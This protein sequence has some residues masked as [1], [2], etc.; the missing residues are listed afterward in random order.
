MAA[1]PSAAQTPTLPRLIAINKDFTD[2]NEQISQ[3]A[4]IIGLSQD[5]DVPQKQNA[6]RSAHNV[7]GPRAEWALR[8]VLDKLKNQADPGAQARANSRSWMLLQWTIEILPISRCAN[9]LRDADFLSILEQTLQESFGRENAAENTSWEARNQDESDSSETV[10]GESPSRKRKRPSSGTANPSKKVNLGKNGLQQLFIAVRSVICAIT[11]KANIQSGLGQTVDSELMK[12]VLRGESYQADQAARVMKYWLMAAQ[13]LLALGTRTHSEELESVLDL[14]PVQELWDLRR[15]DAEDESGTSAEQFSAECL[16]PTLG[17]LESLRTISE[18]TYHGHSY[19]LEVGDRIRHLEKLIERHLLAPARAA[20]FSTQSP[21]SE[22]EPDTKYPEAGSFRVYLAPLSA[23]LLQ[24]AQLEDANEPVPVF[25]NSLYRAVPELLD[26]AIRFSPLRTPKKRLTEKPW[27]QAVFVALVDSIGCSLKAPEFG[28]PQASFTALEGCLNVLTQQDIAIDTE[29]L[30]DLFWFHSGVKYPLNQ[31]RNINWPLVAALV[32]LEPGMFL[33]DPKSR[34]S[35]SE[36]RPVELAGFLFNQISATNFTDSTAAD[37]EPMDIDGGDPDVGVA[38]SRYTFGRDETLSRVIIPIM[39][40]FARNRDLIGFLGKWDDQLCQTA[41]ISREPLKELEVPI[42]QDRALPIALAKLFEQSLTP[43]QISKLFQEHSDRIEALSVLGEVS[44]SDAL[45]L[46]KEAFSSTVIV[47][48]M[49]ECLESDE[50]VEAVKPQLLSLLKSFASHVHTDNHG[51][52][53]SLDAS[54]LVLCQ[55][56]NIIWPIGLHGSSAMQQEVLIPITE[57]AS[58]DVAT[59]RNHESERKIGSSTRAAAVLFLLCACGHLQTIPD[60]AELVRGYLRKALKSLSTSRFDLDDLRR[61]I[62]V[63]CTEFAPLIKFLKEDARQEAIFKLLLSI[64]EFEKEHAKQV[65]EALTQSISRDGGAAVQEP[66]IS[67]L[68]QAL[69]DGENEPLKAIVESSFLQ[70]NPL[71]VSREQREAAL[72]ELLKL[73]D[74]SPNDSALVLN[75]MVRFMHVPNA[76]AKIASSGGC[77]FDIAQKLHDEKLESP[78]ELQ[79]L[80]MLVQLTL[81][82]IIPNKDQDQNKRYLEKF[83]GKLASASKKAHK[84]FPARIAILRGTFLAQK[85]PSLLSP[86]A[87]VKVLSSCLKEGVPWEAVVVDALSE[88]ASKLSSSNDDLFSTAKAS[89]QSWIASKVDMKNVIATKHELS[90]TLPAELWPRVHAIVAKFQLYSSIQWL[91]EFSVGVLNQPIDGLGIIS[92]L[93]SF[94][95]AMSG[96][97][98]REKLELVFQCIQEKEGAHVSQ[99]RLAHTIISTLEE[100]P[101]EDAE[102]KQQQLSLLPKLCL[103]LPKSPDHASFNAILD[104]INTILREKPLLGDQHGIETLL[105]ALA[106]MASR[107][108]PALPNE[109]ASNLFSRLCETSRLVVLLHRSR[110]GHRFHLVLPLLQSL[111]FCL[112]VPHAGRGASLPPWLKS[113]SPSHSVRLTPANAAQYTHL[114]G[115][116]CSPTQSSVQKNKFG[117][118]ISSKKTLND[119]VKAAREYTSEYLYPLLSSYSRFQLNGR[120]EPEV[121]AKLIA[122]IMEAVGLAATNK[123]FLDAMFAGMD[124]STKDVWRGVWAEYEREHGRKEIKAGQ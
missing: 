70:I 99:Y 5:W 61:I 41:T 22:A 115:T 109:Q 54:W 111:L 74:A 85:E 92:V 2:L 112:F 87:Y 28:A 124:R 101:G 57:H 10:Q 65:A 67:A 68:L 86:K 27:I 88:G 73:L 26:L 39:S 8:W 36:E 46:L 11:I 90:A 29:I 12:M 95:Q 82:H 19:H 49:L 18:S 100:K 75:I 47:R 1:N 77:L 4:Q 25:F 42:W 23:K 21:E 7:V 14:S 37:G 17:L 55:L 114:L 38:K 79:S 50:T 44:G 117:S 40:A 78:S 71:S 83:E 107:N 108:G 102:V 104:C 97:S 122:G 118:A 120:L 16:I 15:V 80:Q 98:T 69:K 58:K 84:C 48:A 32:Q 53:L 93:R 20:F 91:V 64:S 123:S 94:R 63:F 113:V 119:P 13:S 35:N 52:D 3:A 59:S 24:A 34:P 33:G 96:L 121:R 89:L 103:M 76:T 9:H 62:E 51:S 60:R 6:D 110:L 106:K 66:F 45:E 72:D 81:G 105:A 116:L 30:R 56:L 43:T 31:E